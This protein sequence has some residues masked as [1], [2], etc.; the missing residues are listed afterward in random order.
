M[1][2]IFPRWTNTMPL[3]VLVSIGV[4]G[5][6]VSVAVSYYF[7]PKY[8][9]VGY[10]PDQPVPYDHKLHVGQLGMDCRYCH[11]FVENSG[12]ANVPSASTC[13]NCHQHVKTGSPKLEPIRKAA[14]KNYEG[15]DGKPVEWVRV[16]RSPDYVYFDHTAHVNRGVSCASCH[17]DVGEM[18]V[19]HHAESHS[20]SWCLDCHKNPEKHLRPLD[21]VFNLKWKPEDLSRS[22]FVDYLSGKS[23]SKE[24]VEELLPSPKSGKDDE[25]LSQEE[26]GLAL[27]ELWKIHPPSPNNCSGCHR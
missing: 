3:K 18:R 4:L 19:V 8:T 26:I 11:S 7:T 21:E 10:Q 24:R 1:A 17:G 23:G 20:M 12:H 5:L 27:K 16:H 6:G 14:D 9:R 22:D 25:P 15:F 13:W 2:N